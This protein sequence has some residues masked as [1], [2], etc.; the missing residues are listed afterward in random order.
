MADVD[1][2]CDKCGST[3]TVSEF[4]DFEAMYCRRCGEKLNRDTRDDDRQRLRIRPEPEPE[5]QEKPRR[6][7]RTPNAGSAEVMEAETRE[8]K[9][10]LP[11][12]RHAAA[13]HKRKVRLTHMTA[14]WILFI[15]LGGLMYVLRYRDEVS[16]ALIDQAFTFGPYLLAALHVVIVLRAF[17]DSV[18]QGILCLLVPLYSAYYL[19]MVSDDFYLRALVA[20]LLVG[21]GQ[22]SMAFY[23]ELITNVTN[24]VTAWIAS[25]G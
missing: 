7:R 10:Y 20:G 15:V 5:P 3:V 21:I 23:Q 18:F 12:G 25:G 14:S 2:H 17:T 8:D 22:D 6:R 4:V 9:Q 24:A 1:V 16:S 13:H 11:G 19:F